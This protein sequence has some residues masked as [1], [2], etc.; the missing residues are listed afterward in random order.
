MSQCGIRRAICFQPCSTHSGLWDHLLGSQL[1]QLVE[2]WSQD[3]RIN[4]LCNSTSIGTHSTSSTVVCVP[5][6]CLMG[7]VKTQTV[8]SD[9]CRTMLQAP[10]TQVSSPLASGQWFFPPAPV[11]QPRSVPTKEL[12]DIWIRKR[13]LELQC[14]VSQTTS[15]ST[16]EVMKQHEKFLRTESLK[17][18][19]PHF[20][21]W[22]TV[23]WCCLLLSWTRLHYTL[24]CTCCTEK[25]V[26][27]S[28]VVVKL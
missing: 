17:R 7:A 16:Q 5:S 1:I 22:S 6:L 26:E 19:L 20:Y 18:H 3:L 9:L 15:S 12:W 24:H 27:M 8:G 23:K 25:H 21:L 4:L 14:L 28:E 13:A 11:L 2:R 10:M